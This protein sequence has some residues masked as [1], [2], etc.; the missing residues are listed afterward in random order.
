MK[1]RVIRRKRILLPLLGIIL[2]IAGLVL[3]GKT[4]ITANV[5]SSGAVNLK[6]SDPSKNCNLDG[7]LVID[8]VSI[9][10]TQEG[11]IS[12]PKTQFEKENR[13][14]KIVLNGYSSS[15]YNKD[16][17]LPFSQEW[18]L[19]STTLSEK[20]E[21]SFITNLSLRVP[22]NYDSA[23]KFIDSASVKDYFE[24]N[25]RSKMTGDLNE[26]LVSISGIRMTYISDEDLFNSNNYWQKA[27][28]TL[29]RKEGDCEDW[30][31]AVVSLIKYYNPE[32]DCYALQWQDHISVLCYNEGS[33]SMIDQANTKVTGV[34]QKGDGQI[35]EIEN[36]AK[37]REMLNT[38]FSSFGFAPGEQEIQAVF[39]DNS[40]QSFDNQ[41]EFINWMIALNK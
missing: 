6:F 7:E 33:Y 41:E 31:I 19:S 5:V 24:T 37:L 36:K 30:S 21:V 11:S 17:N 28:E 20:N 29:N 10:N 9:G 22:S 16:S 14:L 8:G 26:D 12:V 35:N 34:L 2:L 4:I 1:R 3:I 39:D 15:C 25:L 38:Y 18:E 40:S 13:D 32:L 23:E 27:S